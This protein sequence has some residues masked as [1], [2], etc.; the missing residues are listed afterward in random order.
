MLFIKYFNLYFLIPFI[1]SFVTLNSW[2]KD[3]CFTIHDLSVSRELYDNYLKSNA[4]KTNVTQAVISN[5]GKYGAS[6]DKDNNNLFIHNF[7]RK[8]VMVHSYDH[9][10]YPINRVHRISNDGKYL[11]VFVQSNKRSNLSILQLDNL[12]ITIIPSIDYYATESVELSMDSQW[13]GIQTYNS[14]RK[15]KL[16]IVN[17]D[18]FIKSNAAKGIIETTEE[19]EPS[20]KK[21]KL[22]NITSERAYIL[23]MLSQEYKIK[24]F[25]FKDNKS[26]YI[27]LDSSIV[28][29]LYLDF[30]DIPSFIVPQKNALI[31]KGFVKDSREWINTLIYIDISDRGFLQLASR[32]QI[33]KTLPTNFKG[34]LM[35]SSE[36][37]PMVTPRIGY[38]SGSYKHS[39]NRIVWNVDTDELVEKNI[40][41]TILGSYPLGN[42]FWSDGDKEIYLLSHLFI[43]KE[44]KFTSCVKPIKITSDIEFAP[45]ISCTNKSDSCFGVNIA[46]LQNICSAP[47]SP[48]SLR[49]WESLIPNNREFLS[50]ESAHILLLKWS[51]PGGF[52]F[53]QDIGALLGVLKS[54]KEFSKIEV[55]R[56]L[57]G[58]Y[59]YSKDVYEQIIEHFPDYTVPSNQDQD[60]DLYSCRTSHEES[61]FFKEATR[62]IKEM[63]TPTEQGLKFPFNVWSKL[64]PFGE[65]I[66]KLPPD[67]WESIADQVSQSLTDDLLGSFYSLQSMESK[68]YN[69]IYTQVSSVLGKP[70]SH[71]TD[72]TYL[73]NK[74]SITP[75]IM[76]SSHITILN[77]NSGRP[78]VE[79]TIYG[80]HFATFPEVEVDEKKL[81]IGTNVASLQYEWKVDDNIYKSD[82]SVVLNKQ[83]PS[84][85]PKGDKPNYPSMLRDGVLTG[86]ILLGANIG[87]DLPKYLDEYRLYLYNNNFNKTS[88]HQQNLIDISSEIKSKFISGEVDYWIKEHH[89]EGGDDMI[90]KITRM[91]YMEVFEKKNSKGLITERVYIVYSRNDKNRE[92]F[93][94]ANRDFADWFKMR[95]K[96]VPA[97]QFLLV[98]AS[99][100]SDSPTIR[101]IEAI[102]SRNFLPIPAFDLTSGIFG[103]GEDYA[104]SPMWDG[105]REQRDY[106]WIEKGYLD[107]KKSTSERARFTYLFPN[108]EVYR[109]KILDFLN[110][111]LSINFR[112]TENGKP[113]S[114]LN[115]R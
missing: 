71:V 25:S 70:M 85:L 105:L 104:R 82:F 49:Q 32:K 31:F 77:T 36:G 112:V 78:K 20:L 69:F 66:K 23:Q 16:T 90:L 30:N 39:G 80:F 88:K 24:V 40:S 5:N 57:Q 56:A 67:E 81:S 86:M 6:I 60:F 84:I 110:V 106:A 97:N 87:N 52:N 43:Q 11:L 103:M 61:T 26:E 28:E 89:M 29:N 76:A 51:K 50:I 8:E 44:R 111:M 73:R 22:L 35:I 48:E 102:Q 19:S 2:G 101:Q 33:R 4:V 74:T 46:S 58:V 27:L 62:T 47:I 17:I 94:I 41:S 114:Y 13:I 96:R 95:D 34:F 109:K 93:I 100:Y 42:Y 37:Y 64:T 38:D 7:Q 75:V 3:Q 98:N 21:E 55:N 79:N 15:F 83:D 113:Y 108:G 53:Q 92:Y 65:L 72:L 14:D 63:L 45:K 91:G 1:F 18:D 59:H 12:N 10:N 115:S 107:M 9:F 68:V 54:T 99:C